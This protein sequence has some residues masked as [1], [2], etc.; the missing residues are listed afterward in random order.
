MIAIILFSLFIYLIIKKNVNKEIILFLVLIYLLNCLSNQ[1]LIEG[2]DVEDAADFVG[3]GDEYREAEAGTA[4]IWCPPKHGAALL[5]DWR[6]TLPGATTQCNAL[7]YQFDENWFKGVYDDGDDNEICREYINESSECDS[8]GCRL[9]DDGRCIPE[10]IRHFNEAVVNCSNF[11]DNNPRDGCET[12]QEV[13]NDNVGYEN[14][15]RWVTDED[16][17]ETCEYIYGGD[18]YDR[19]CSDSLTLPDCSLSQDE[20]TCSHPLCEWI[21]PVEAVEATETEPAVEAVAGTCSEKVLESVEKINIMKNLCDSKNLIG[22]GDKENSCHYRLQCNDDNT[23]E[24]ICEYE[25][26]TSDILPNEY[27]ENLQGSPCGE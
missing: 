25:T 10:W 17:N 16:G 12:H 8:E 9:A 24:H 19:I 3:L 18:F 7:R 14:I 15:C 27:E 21:P 5:T 20:A 22:V 6:Q 23:E 13:E 11:K 26:V 1:N 4:D 2:L